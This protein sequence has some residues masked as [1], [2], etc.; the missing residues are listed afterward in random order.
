MNLGYVIALIIFFFSSLS[1]VLIRRKLTI[2]KETSEKYK[3][4]IDAI[5]DM[6]FV[7]DDRCRIVEHYNLYT[8]DLLVP[9]GQLAKKDIRELL[10]PDLTRLIETGLQKVRETSEIY[11]L[12]YELKVS[13]VTKFYEA[14][15]LKIKEGLTG[16]LIRNI[17]KR[18]ESEIAMKNSR[19]LLKAVLDNIPF[20]VMVKDI[21]DE[22]RYIYWNN[23]C[24]LQSG[25]TKKDSV[26][27]TDIDLYGEERG[28]R[29]REID[30][31][32]VKEGKI[33]RNQEIFRTPDGVIHDTIVT[34]N[35][36]SNDE[37]RWLLVIRWDI[38]EVTRA[39]RALRELNQLNQL[40]LNNSDVGF[41]FIGADHVVQWENVSDYISSP[42]SR[43]YKK[44]NLCY[45]SVK[46]LDHPCPDCVMEKAVRSGK[47]EREEVK[48]GEGLIAEVVAT[49]V[50]NEEQQLQGAVLKVEDVTAKRQA[51]KE[52][53]LA[54]EEA[55]KSD[56]LKSAFLANMS[57]EIRTPLNA[58]VGFS[59][60]LCSTENEQEREE[61]IQVIRNNNE[62]LLQLINDILDL[63][64]IE[65]D[66]LEFI[67][68]DVDINAML[69]ELK[70]SMNYR[71]ENTN[72][73]IVFEPGLAECIVYTEKNR[74]LQVVSNLINN[75]IKFTEKGKITFGYKWQEDRLYFYVSDTGTGIPKE[76]QNE[77]FRRFVKLDSFKHGTGL[78]L[79]IC[80]LIVAR[81]K[82][83]IGVDSE[84]G[85]GSTFW[86]TIPCKL[87][88]EEKTIN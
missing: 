13:G 35:I 54:K 17:S 7:F 79:S 67:Y 53:Q 78:G 12:E 56:K 41:I 31:Q 38:S 87:L 86:F 44:G 42:I 18:K 37:Y 84:L 39:E 51:Q 28:G 3:W 48:F 76:K 77:I 8:N 72:V 73:E 19:I 45:A 23:E 33:Y 82:G 43:A 22:F 58:I 85:K 5:P 64:K 55:E 75:A 2:L 47:T 24:E 60:L 29:Y 61:Y 81:L 59:E 57:H 63:S 69:Q 15:F 83:E 20:P 50:W 34:K 32:L 10:S 26:G 46:H 80:Q 62:L 21:N 52:L 11:E 14:R 40:I 66:T 70:S 30:K 36:I 68:S 25:F 74:L 16:C 71:M 4:I 65:A 6:I 49:P 9:E 1:I 88:G 27:K